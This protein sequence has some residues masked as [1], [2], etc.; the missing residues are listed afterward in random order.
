MN[1]VTGKWKGPQ[2]NVPNCLW[3]EDLSFQAGEKVNLETVV[4]VGSSAG[5]SLFLYGIEASGFKGL[6]L[7]HQ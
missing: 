6:E 5:L 7:A 2:A 1:V 4:I 3:V